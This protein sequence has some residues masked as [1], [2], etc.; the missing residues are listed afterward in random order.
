MGE[1]ETVAFT[2]CCTLHVLLRSAIQQTR[3][4]PHKRIRVVL[5]PEHIALILLTVACLN[6]GPKRDEANS[7]HK[8]NKLAGHQGQTSQTQHPEL[9]PG[10]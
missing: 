5:S 6:S 8:D 4:M 1:N 2:C 3:W 9:L 10:V 7:L